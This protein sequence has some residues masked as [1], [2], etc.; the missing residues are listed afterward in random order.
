MFGTLLHF[1]YLPKFEVPRPE[2]GGHATLVLEV[3]SK[4]CMSKVIDTFFNVF[5]TMFFKLIIQ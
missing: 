5:Y 1:D 2:G 4:M 3:F